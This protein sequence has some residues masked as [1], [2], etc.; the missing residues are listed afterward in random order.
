MSAAATTHRHPVF[1]ELVEADLNP[2][3]AR[4]DGAVCVDAGVRLEPWP[5]FDQYLRRFRRPAA[6]EGK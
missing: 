2:V 6:A 3:I 1:P 4:P 5:S